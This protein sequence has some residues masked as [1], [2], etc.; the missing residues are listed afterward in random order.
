MSQRAIDVAQGKIG[1]A[2]L[3]ILTGAS[4]AL[5]IYEAWTLIGSVLLPLL[6]NPLAIQTDFHYYY[7]AAGRFSADRSLL[8]LPTDDVI[9]GFAYPPP[10]IVPFMVL[11]QMPLGAALLVMTIASYAAIAAATHRWLYHLSRSGFDSDFA[12]RSAI[13]LI[14]LASGPTYMNAIFGQVNAFVLLSAVIFLT[15]ADVTPIIAGTSL[16]AGIALKI[17]PIVAAAVVLWNR[18]AA[19]ALLWTVVAGIATVIVLLPIVPL[20]A[21]ASF[22]GVLSARIDKTAL[23][24]TNQSLLGFLERFRV[25]PELFLNWTGH[26]AVTVS[27]M[28]RGI[29]SAVLVVAVIALWKRSRSRDGAIA[30]TAALIA[31][32]AVIA[33][34]G[35]GH[36]YVMVLPLVVLQLINMREARAITA[37]LIFLCVAALMIPAGRHLPIDRAPD[38]IENIVYSRYLLATILMIL[39]PSRQKAVVPT[40]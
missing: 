13:L 20:A 29:N 6:R 33:P 3:W 11:A 7:Q 9:A 37:I 39:I 2:L 4:I 25:A 8:Y 17:Y 36:T 1:A 26:E 19:R 21:Y 12:T 5:L 23:H 27:P 34:L 31:L 16:A 15:M 30:S 38:W 24:I 22:F 40:T 35:W 32:I 14:V 18:R 28:L 10:A